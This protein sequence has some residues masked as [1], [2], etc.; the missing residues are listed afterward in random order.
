MSPV[1]SDYGLS[2]GAIVI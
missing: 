1:T 2:H